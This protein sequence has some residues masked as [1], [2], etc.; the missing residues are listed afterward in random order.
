MSL[1][2][3]DELPIL[4]KETAINQLDDV[5]L[6]ETM[7]V[8]FE[9]MSMRSNLTD[10]KIAIEKLDYSNIRLSS[11]SLKGASSYIHA[12]RVKTVASLIQ[13]AIDD[14]QIDSIN[15]YYSVL[16]KQCILLKKAI[17]HE[18]CT[19]EAKPF[20]DDD[21]DF[22]VPIAANFKVIKKSSDDFEVVQIGELAGLTKKKESIK[23]GDALT[24]R[25]SREVSE[26]IENMMEIKTNEE[27]KSA[28]C[29]CNVI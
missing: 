13:S 15:K 12:E 5:E 29:N 7:I 4:D 16:I 25:K 11:H 28:C 21:N 6:F 23:K 14:N 27:P 24:D 8:G 2:E 9:D 18:M 19:K 26:K 20:E 22:D 1:D 10:L 3:I 17:R